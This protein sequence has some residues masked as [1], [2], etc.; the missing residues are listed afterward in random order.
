MAK[1]LV[2]Y[3]TAYVLWAI[4]L[5]LGVWLLVLSR[6]AFLGTLSQ[7]YVHDDIV[8]SWQGRF[9]DRAFLVIIG[10]IWMLFAVLA[11][12]SLRT[13]VRSGYLFIRFAR[14]CGPALLLSFVADSWLL[15]LQGVSSLDWLRA[16]VLF[17]ELVLGIAL[18]IYGRSVKLKRMRSGESN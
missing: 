5:L 11:E 6:E 1:K 16:L 4:F 18:L 13:G 10:L 9:F 3:I 7:Y 15:W 17:L 14:F 8:R 2:R 12:F